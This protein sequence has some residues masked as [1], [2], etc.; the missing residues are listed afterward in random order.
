MINTFS[1]V[2]LFLFQHVLY[3]ELN[4]VLCNV[5]DWFFFSNMQILQYHMINILFFSWSKSVFHIIIFIAWCVTTMAFLSII[6]NYLPLWQ[7]IYFFFE[8]FTSLTSVEF[9][10]NYSHQWQFISSFV[11]MSLKSF[12]NLTIFQ[13]SDCLVDCPPF[14]L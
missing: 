6:W 9:I 3:K 4:S 11:E 8:N 7:K 2:G 5:L 10:A 1:W 14:T 13:C 12:Q